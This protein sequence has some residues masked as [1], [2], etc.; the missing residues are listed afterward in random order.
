MSVHIVVV[1][2]AGRLPK[3]PAY[4]RIAEI[5]ISV[6]GAFNNTSAPRPPFPKILAQWSSAAD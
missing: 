5:A 2:Q 1:A 3:M 4:E 6:V